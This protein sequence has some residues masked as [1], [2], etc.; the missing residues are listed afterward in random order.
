MYLYSVELVNTDV[1][2]IWLIAS[3]DLSYSRQNTGRIVALAIKSTKAKLCFVVMHS[4]IDNLIVDIEE[5]TI[6]LL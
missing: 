4:N 1:A 3:K 5:R 6:S 2:F